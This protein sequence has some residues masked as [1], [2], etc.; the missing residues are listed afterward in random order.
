MKSLR[1]EILLRKIKDKKII[2]IETPKK[3]LLMQVF[4]SMK[5]IKTYE[6]RNKSSSYKAI[7][8]A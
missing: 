8:S 1:D 2:K 4:F 7:L 6:K 5:R 3:H